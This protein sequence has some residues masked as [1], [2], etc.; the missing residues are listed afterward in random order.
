MRIME[1]SLYDKKSDRT[2]I[3]NLN[4]KKKLQKI[5]PPEHIIVKNL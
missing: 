1:T 4:T 5:K 3:N 2:Y